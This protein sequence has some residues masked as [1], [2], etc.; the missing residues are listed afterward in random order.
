ME[1]GTLKYPGSILIKPDAKNNLSVESIV[2]VF[3]LRAIDK[4][5]LVRRIGK[6][7]SQSL[8]KIKRLIIEF[9]D[10]E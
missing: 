8:Q 3:Q 6:I 10:Y 4:S 1:I 5:R 9:I 7:N 2:M